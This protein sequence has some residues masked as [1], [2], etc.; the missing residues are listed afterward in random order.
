MTRTFF[1]TLLISS[2]TCQA[3]AAQW[4]VNLDV[5]NFAT[6][7]DIEQNS[8]FNPDNALAGIEDTRFD[9]Q[10]KPY[11]M[12]R[13][14]RLRTTAMPRLELTLSEVNGTQ[15][16]TT[17]SYLQEW[18]LSY[19][20]DHLS[21]NLG[22]ELLYWSP[23]VNF[24]PSNPFYASINQINP[25]VEPRAAEFFRARYALNEHTSLSFISNYDEG[26]NT[27]GSEYTKFKTINAIKLDHVGY[28][29]SGGGVLALRE[30]KMWL[31]GYGQWTFNDATVLYFDAAIRQGSEALVPQR[32]DALPAGWEF[33]AAHD[34][35]EWLTDIL[36]GG[37][38]TFLNGAILTLEY[39]HN[40][41]GYS[42]SQLDDFYQ[43][44]EDAT[45]T[46]ISDPANIPYASSLLATA[47]NPHTR[48]LGRNYLT[49]QLLKRE[50]FVE[51][52][53]LNF[54]VQSNLDDGGS[55]LLSIVTYYINSNWRFNGYLINNFGGTNS[56]PGRYFETS[57]YLGFT[58]FSGPL[59]NR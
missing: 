54:I 5:Q 13:E 23:A 42:H 58:W 4:L 52:L 6:L 32:N 20:G 33:S 44:A 25:F 49:L 1:S 9:I 7:A 18:S 50:A 51:D 47:A 22:R 11:L 37:S 55:Q 21:L 53:S 10:M 46:L 30:R 41:Q 8:P 43:L 24:S 31:G 39:R 48:S 36:L 45:Q 35:N 56:E 40:Q 27:E 19:F 38:Y 12:F 16:S 57:L 34:P 17:N 2:M 59:F 28:E 3:C 14:G 26:R 15:E 29:F